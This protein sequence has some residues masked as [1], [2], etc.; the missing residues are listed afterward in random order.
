MYLP[1]YLPSQRYR[2]YFLDAERGRNLETGQIKLSLSLEEDVS[3][4]VTM[5]LGSAF[6]RMPDNNVKH[7]K[8]PVLS[9]DIG[10]SLCRT[11]VD[12]LAQTR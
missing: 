8:R 6:I 3:A 10:R 5:L 1:R 4:I 7:N 2:E 9:P 11:I 12:M